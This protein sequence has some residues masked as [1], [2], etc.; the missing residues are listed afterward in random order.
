LVPNLSDTDLLNIQFFSDNGLTSLGSAG[1]SFSGTEIVPV[2]E[3]SV[4][5]ASIL[6]VALMAFAKREQIS[7]LARRIAVR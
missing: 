5:L 3:P 7:R 2:P 1:G 4:V 6:I